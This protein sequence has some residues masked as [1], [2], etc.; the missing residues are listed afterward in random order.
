[1]HDAES[2][3]WNFFIGRGSRNAIPVVRC[4]NWTIIVRSTSNIGASSR[5]G[6]PRPRSHLRFNYFATRN[7]ANIRQCVSSF[8]SSRRKSPQSPLRPPSVQ[9]ARTRNNSPVD[10][11]GFPVREHAGARGSAGPAICRIIRP[12]LVPFLRERFE[13]NKLRTCVTR[14]CTLWCFINTRGAGTLSQRQSRETQ[15][16]PG[17][18]GIV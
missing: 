13:G 2:V 7:C 10:G 11:R 18:I 1:M 15:T 17:N 5:G 16:D 9:R 6:G 14:A 12:F 4:N 8:P 3:H